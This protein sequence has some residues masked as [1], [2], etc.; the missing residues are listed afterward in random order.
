[1]AVELVQ[2]VRRARGGQQPH[3]R[4]TGGQESRPRA[5]GQGSMPGEEPAASRPRGGTEWWTQHS[6]GEKQAKQNRYQKIF[7]HL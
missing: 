7:K 4:A 3:L 1:M 6:P 2:G 5:V